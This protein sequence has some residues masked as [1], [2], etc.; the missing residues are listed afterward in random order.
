LAGNVPRASSETGLLRRFVVIRERW[1]LVFWQ[2]MIFQFLKEH[3]Y[4]PLELRVV[5]LPDQRRVIIDFD[6]GR[7]AMVLDIPLLR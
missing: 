7:H 3:L 2:G 5:A 4:R 1:S 6:I